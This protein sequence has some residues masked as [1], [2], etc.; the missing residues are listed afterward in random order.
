[1]E[2]IRVNPVNHHWK[3]SV[4]LLVLGISSSVL[5]LCSRFLRTCELM[6]DRGVSF[7][8]DS[9]C[10]MRLLS[11]SLGSASSLP[12]KSSPLGIALWVRADLEPF[13]RSLFPCF[14]KSRMA[15]CSD[16]AYPWL[17]LRCPFGKKVKQP[18]L[19]SRSVVSDSL[20]PHR[21]QPTLCCASPSPWVC[22]NSCPSNRWCHPTISASGSFPVS[23]PFTGDQNGGASASALPMNIQHWFPLGLTGLISW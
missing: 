6:K 14:S 8:L 9:W 13:I 19:S 5:S 16:P 2:W 4:I 23:R 22:S 1:M 11:A 10:K 3:T 7:F 20:R 18:L 17:I 12:G 21:W 15:F